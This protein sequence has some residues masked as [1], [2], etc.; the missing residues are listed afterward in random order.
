MGKKAKRAIDPNFMFDPG[1][2]L[3][4]PQSM[5]VPPPPTLPTEAELDAEA[6]KKARERERKAAS[7]GRG[8]TILTDLGGGKTILG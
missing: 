2:F 4:E 7:G 3:D 1:G 5:D 6:K 8:S